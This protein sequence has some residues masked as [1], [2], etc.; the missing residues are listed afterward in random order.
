MKT[1]LNRREAL[2][3]G[4]AM[5]AGFSALARPSIKKYNIG[6]QLYSVRE[7]MKKDPLGTLKKVAAMGYEQVEHANYVNHTFY[8]Y[9]AKEFRKI[10]DDLGLTMP[11]SHTGFGKAHWNKAQNDITDVWKKTIEDA[12]ITGQKLVIVPSFDWDKKNLD[13]CKKGFEAFN[14]CGEICDKSGLR[15][16][17]HNHHQ[18]FEQKFNGEYL[19]DIMLREW[20]SK[21]VTQQLDIANMAVADMDPLVWI[22]KYPKHFESIHVKDLDGATKESTLLGTGKL[23]MEKILEFCKKN[24]P[25]KYW[26]I[27]QEAYGNKTPLECVEYDLK[28]FKNYGFA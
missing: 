2:A 3:A 16:G 19:Y 21:Y 22:A 10:L 27:E 23:D 24:T 26:V 25:I 15:L 13:E 7:D 17:F 12:V 8:G 6:L 28:R 18:E 9:K 11:T 1:T 14:R 20:D 4:V 5:L